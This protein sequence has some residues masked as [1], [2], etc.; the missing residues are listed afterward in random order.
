MG[1]NES[2]S[3]AYDVLVGRTRGWL[4]FYLIVISVVAVVR[5]APIATGV[6]VIGL[7]S[8][9]G[10]LD[11]ISSLVAEVD[12]AAFSEGGFEDPED[13]EA[14][15]VGPLSEAF[16]VLV[17]TPGV[18]PAVAF[19]ALAFVFVAIVANA[20]AGAARTHAL[21]SCLCGDD[22]LVDG[23]RGG[24]DDY[25]V[26]V[27]LAL[28]ELGV[29]VAVTGLFAVLGGLV[30]SLGGVA[31][32]ALGVVVALVWFVSVVSVHLFFVFAP[33]AVVVDG[34]SVSG[35]LR[36]NLG[37]LRREPADFLGYLV[38]AV[39]AVFAFGT[40]S[41]LLSAF[42]ANAAGGLFYFLV[43]LP[44]LEM[45][46]THLYADHRGAFDGGREAPKS[47]DDPVGRLS[48]ELRRG[49]R[50]LMEFVVDGRA[51]ILGSALVLAGFFWFGFGFGEEHLAPFESSIEARLS[52][53][54]PP[55]AFLNFAANNWMV[56]V[57]SAYSGL[58]LGLPA[59]V[60]MAFNGML[61]G[62]LSATEADP[63]RLLGFVLPHGVLEIPAIVVSGGLGFWLGGVSLQYAR[64]GVGLD[65]VVA[66]VERAY[67]VLLGV[68]VVVVVAAFVEAFVSPY[69]VDVLVS[70]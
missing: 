2:F 26:F 21:Y 41:G 59:L 7:L 56:S 18:V 55:G 28:L 16:D 36:N 32:A 24:L 9:H 42:G 53:H 57:A 19:S 64:G 54:F 67:Y 15:D 37:F 39:V 58:V 60:S 34:E 43:I 65:V 10:N 70:L 6:I 40:V 61:L 8:Y 63:L 52:G 68:L 31:G 1:L 27:G 35:A 12:W 22:S 50:E 23:V 29:V 4:P 14:L 46:K 66:A 51:W 48:G 69:Y 33:Q 49:W 3:A 38:V 13:V 44:S 62:A 17:S 30:L 25:D 11:E 20:V 5:V 47:V 45:V